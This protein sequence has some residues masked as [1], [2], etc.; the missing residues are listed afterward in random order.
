MT[1][2]LV[3]AVL[4]A[5]DAYRRTCASVAGQT[6]CAIEHI[7]VVSGGE[8]PQNRIA[9]KIPPRGVYNALNVGLSKATGDVVGLLHGGD[10]FAT[11]DELRRVAEEFRQ[12]PDIDYIYGDIAYVR[13]DGSGPHGRIHRGTPPCEHDLRRGIYPP[14][15]TLYIRRKSAEKLGSYSEEYKIC[16]DMDMWVR[17]YRAGL[18]GLYL[19]GIMVL[20]TTGGL[21]TRLRAR[22]WTNNLE[23]LRVLAAHGL[24]PNPFLLAAKY[25]QILK[26]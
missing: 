10:V 19:P 13:P 11:N 15:P 25:V 8:M 9:V 12:N 24:R 2:S 20:M 21:S 4:T 5:D 3:T 22:L 14:H 26:K 6:Y 23:K 1:I 7:T 18:K 16:G 17:I